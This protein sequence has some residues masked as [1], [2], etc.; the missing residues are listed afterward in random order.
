MDLILLAEAFQLPSVLLNDGTAVLA[1]K[2]KD[3]SLLRKLMKLFNLWD[4]ACN[5]M[6]PAKYRSSNGTSAMVGVYRSLAGPF[7]D[8][9]P[10]DITVAFC[11]YVEYVNTELAD[12]SCVL[13]IGNRSFGGT[14]ELV[15]KAVMD[16]Y[17]GFEAMADLKH[18]GQKVL[19]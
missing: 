1:F 8:I 14:E 6:L 15:N 2:K 19:H 11:L 16:A 7:E 17:R 10:S 13:V 3:G 18:P 5:D 12:T 9:G 4:M